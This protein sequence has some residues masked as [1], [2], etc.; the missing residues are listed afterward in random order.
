MEVAGRV[1][2]RIGGQPEC[3]WGKS[4][5]KSQLLETAKSTNTLY[6]SN[7]V[8][9]IPRQPWGFCEESCSYG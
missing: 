3:Y 5:E 1:V 4:A 8:T 9:Q 7:R 2:L 6:G